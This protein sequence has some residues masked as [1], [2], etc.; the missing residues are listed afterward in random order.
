MKDDPMKY[1]LDTN[2]IILLLR[3]NPSVCRKFDAAV[4]RGDMFVIP[5]LVHYEM[6]RGFLCYPAPKKEKSYR[7]LTSQYP[8][9]EMNEDS[10]V[11][12]ASLYADL[13]RIGRTVDDTDLLI[14]AYCITND[15]AL[16]THNV[17]HFEVIDSLRIEDWVSD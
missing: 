15:F 14:A 7:I 2:I 11:R 17:R 8:V 16:V 10:L 4:E 12:G 3:D 5:P 13:W 9:G 6:L 1:A